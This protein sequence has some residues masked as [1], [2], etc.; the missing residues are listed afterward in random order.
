MECRT[1][2]KVLGGFAVG[3]LVVVAL[4]CSSGGENE[5]AP[6]P[7]PG[8]VQV[9]ASPQPDPTAP[10][11]PDPEPTPTSS[12]NVQRPRNPWGDDSNPFDVTSIVEDGKRY[13][14][15]KVLSKDAIPAIFDPSFLTPN[16]AFN[17]YR[18]TDLVIGVSIGGEH[19]AYN[20]AYLSGH[21]IVNDVVG[22][23]PIAVT[24]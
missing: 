13:E 23:K 12:S 15:I 4:A 14:V 18:D 17:Q 1:I 2:G 9:T 5:P 16:E 7:D 20:V 10:A 19:R 11:P 22:G 6:D 21:E 8:A 24:W 3:M